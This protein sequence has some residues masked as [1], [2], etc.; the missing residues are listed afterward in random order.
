MQVGMAKYHTIPEMFLGQ[1]ASHANKRTVNDRVSGGW[2]PMGISDLV[3]KVSCLAAMLEERVPEAGSSIGILAAPSAQWL[4][5]DMAAMLAGHVAVPFFVDFSEAHLLHKVVDANISTIFV[6]GDAL[7]SRLRPY[8]D[9]F[10]LIVTDQVIDDVPSVVHIDELY[11]QGG[12]KLAA[13]PSLPDRLL[14]EIKPDSVAVIIYTSGSTGT[15][16]G[17][18][19]THRNLVAQLRDIELLFPI[20]SC[21]D[22]A[23]SLLP[24]AHSFER[25]VIYLYLAR[26]MSIYFVD[27]ID[28][29][30]VLFQEVQPTMMTVVP[31]LLERTY[32][33]IAEKSNLV[34]G[35]M[36]GLA[37]WT[38]RHASRMEED[39][40]FS[41][42]NFLSDRL[43]GWQ[44]RKAL[45][46]QLRTMVVGGAHMPD[47]LNRFFVR[48][49]VP[50]YE[51]YGLTEA[52]PV[53]SVNYQ[54]NRKVGTVGRP[55]PSVQVKV[56]P[57]GEVLAH[58]ANIM[59]GYHNLPEE[60]SKV[61]DNEGWLHTGDL[62]Q[63]DSDGY[64][65]IVARQKELFKT[66]TGEIVVPQPIE[67]ALSRSDW[68]DMA[69]V[70]AESRKYTSVLL[71]LN[72]KAIARLKQRCGESNEA[73]ASF[74]NSSAVHQE[75]QSLIKQVNADLD[76]WEKIHA[77]A[78]LLDPPTVENGQ[79]TPTLKI[80]RHKVEA[81]YK[82]VIGR[83][84]EESKT[85]EVSHEFTIG[86]C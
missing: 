86:H 72:R 83:I 74:V 23:L 80:R 45:G 43:V 27:D 30:G 48:M 8:A 35:L 55:L 66:S 11:F 78:L 16:K 13:E 2:Q 82:A 70:V 22:R 57:D 14:K 39:S 51:G 34:F 20:K 77:Y 4:V 38:W 32:E 18:E 73:D 19:L 79:L 61:I 56:T 7:W 31:R 10:D 1:A 47:D 25:I 3:L 41:L 12:E 75:I 50:L 60:T 5:V 63:F 6:F 85:R 29:L 42:G 46:G 37:R 9:R 40:G 24:V 53:I 81:S 65:S 68:V 67:R 21:K 49:G 62:G 59:R 26:G 52:A 69:C 33:R 44:I 64:L 71:F 17:V 84:Y 76:H 28:H 15:P 54:G 58:G 36:G